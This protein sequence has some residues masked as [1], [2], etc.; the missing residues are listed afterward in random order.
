MSDGGSVS[1]AVVGLVLGIL[2]GY[3]LAYAAYSPLEARIRALEDDLK[4]LTQ[5]MSLCSEKVD[6]LERRLS[7]DTAALASKVEALE[8]DVES[9]LNQVY[10]M[11][12]RLDLVEERTRLIALR[13]GFLE[14]LTIDAVYVMGSESEGWRL[15]LKVANTGTVYTVITDILLDGSP[16]SSYLGSGWGYTYEKPFTDECENWTTPVS[17]TVDQ[18][19]VVY[20][21]VHIP[22]GYFATG[23]NITVTLHT[24]FGKNYSKTITIQ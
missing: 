11:Q 7:N 4:T 15:Y 16:L 22:S 24:V 17:I 1:Y 21:T 6:G 5:Q 23:Q 13:V 20:L 9:C 2:I 14:K 18:A 8:S 10:S 12:D 3:G 19:S